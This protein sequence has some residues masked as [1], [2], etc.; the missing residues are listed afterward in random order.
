MAEISVYAFCDANCKHRVLTATQTIALIEEVIANGGKVP[1]ELVLST[2]IR[3]IIDQNTGKGLKFFVGTQAQWDAWTGDKTNVFAIITDDPIQQDIF[4]KLDELSAG[5]NYANTRVD[6]V[7]DGRTP[8]TNARNAIVGIEQSSLDSLKSSFEQGYITESQYKTAVEELYKDATYSPLTKSPSDN[9]LRD[10][11]EIISKK[12]LL[13]SG[14]VQADYVTPLDISGLD[15]Q[16]GD[17]LELIIN[18]RYDYPNSGEK[19][20]KSECIVSGGGA[21]NDIL[22][23]N[24]ADMA[25]PKMRIYRASYI[26]DITNKNFVFDSM[27]EC[28]LHPTG[29]ETS[30]TQYGDTSYSGKVPHLLAI[31]K[32]IE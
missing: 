16:S 32:I 11:K 31:Y 5:L 29:V 7:I 20:L 1:E 17:S 24:Y 30:K 27:I 10:G 6:K 21:V 18:W 23:V 28:S 19:K 14:D 12:V 2:P 3:E 25:Q 8:V 13:W 9:V 26:C 22:V 15:I 4:N